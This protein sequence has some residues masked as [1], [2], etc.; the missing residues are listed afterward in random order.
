MDGSEVGEGW[1]VGVEV[2]EEV[3]A[4]EEISEG[5]EVAEGAIVAGKVGWIGDAQPARIIEMRRVKRKD[6]FCMD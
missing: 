2:G 3:E 6:F 4:G 5:I 1:G